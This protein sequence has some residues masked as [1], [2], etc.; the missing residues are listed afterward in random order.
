MRT[1]RQLPLWGLPYGSDEKEHDMS[2]IAFGTAAVL[3][4]RPATRL[5][6]T[7]RGRRV[8]LVLASVPLAAGIA[9]GVLS[10]GSALAS[11]EATSTAT[12]E[13]ITV[14]PGDSLWSIASKVAPNEDPRVV[15]D[16]ISDL[17]MLA[18]ST[19]QVGDE[20]AIPA[21]YSN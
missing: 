21:Q 18:G 6:V 3:P 13:T 20:L 1:L 2:S 17:N 7:T 5:R 4:E 8:L 19:L 9:F 10:G 12:F 16:E 14:V 11:N 15:I